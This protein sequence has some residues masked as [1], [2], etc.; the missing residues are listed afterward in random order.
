MAKSGGL[1]T[2][3]PLDGVWNGCFAPALVNNKDILNL[4]FLPNMVVYLK[5]NY[6]YSWWINRMVSNSETPKYLLALRL[7]AVVYGTSQMPPSELYT[8][9]R[10]L[11]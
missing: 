11:S 2:N 1:E 5:T 10:K 4:I 7:S 6:I 8:T 3:S 9:M